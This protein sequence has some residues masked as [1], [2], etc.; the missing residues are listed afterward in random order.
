MCKKFILFVCM[1]F[2][3]SITAAVYADGEAYIE[4][5]GESVNVESV[6]FQS[7]SLTYIKKADK[8]GYKI[9][10]ESASDKLYIDI[11]NSFIYAKTGQPVEVEVGYYDEGSCSL[12]IGYAGFD[13]NIYKEKITEAVS[14]NNTCEWKTHT[15][16]ISD[17]AF[18]DSCPGKE[19]YDIFVKAAGE[20]EGDYV[21]VSS[22]R[23]TKKAAAIPVTFNIQGTVRG[24]IY[25]DGG[26]TF[27]AVFMN[28]AE[29]HTNVSVRYFVYDEN[30]SLAESGMQNSLALDA[31][32][33]EASV[34]RTNIKKYGVYTLKLETVSR[35]ESGERVMYSESLPFSVINKTTDG[36]VNLDFGISAH[37]D[38]YGNQTENV[39]IIKSAGFG[40]IR[41]ELS[42]FYV[43]HYSNP[44]GDLKI[45]ENKG[46]FQSYVVQNGMDNLMILGF[47]SAH[48]LESASIPPYTDEELEAFANY[49]AFMAEQYKDSV[50]YFEIWNEYNL[51][52]FNTP[53]YDGTVYAKMLKYAYEAIKGAN[54]NAK[55]VGMSLAGLTVGEKYGT[56]WDTF[57][58]QALSA[59]AGNYL[60]IL[61]VHFYQHDNEG[62]Y[63][64]EFFRTQK[65]KP[66]NEILA[67]YNVSLPI[68]LTETGWS[69]V[70][71]DK[72]A[73]PVSEKQQA[74]YGVKLYLFSKAEHLWNRM[75]WYDYQNDGADT[76]ENQHNFGL[77]DAASGVKAPG[78]AKSAFVAFAGMNKLMAGTRFKGRIEREGA[79]ILWFEKDN[80]E[81]VAALWSDGRDGN[82]INLSLG[83]DKIEILD[84]Y[85][86]VKETVRN[87]LGIYSVTFGDEPIYIRGDFVRFEEAEAVPMINI[88]IPDE[89]TYS[90]DVP[91]FK[92]VTDNT[93][94]D[95]KA[96]SVK[97][98]LK[99]YKNDEI[100]D[101]QEII[102]TAEANSIRYMP[103]SAFDAGVGEFRYE[104]SAAVGDNEVSAVKEY[105]VIKAE[106]DEFCNISYADN[107]LCVSG[108]AVRSRKCVSITVL[109]INTK[110]TIYIGQ[111]TAD[112]YGNYEFEPSGISAA[113]F[114]VTVNDGVLNSRDFHADDVCV[115]LLHN[116][117]SIKD[118]S[119]LKDGDVVE[120]YMTVNNTAADEKV[121]VIIAAY[122]GV[123]L[124]WAKSKMLRLSEGTGSVNVSMEQADKTDRLAC[125]VWTENMQPAAAKYVAVRME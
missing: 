106:D 41:D 22:V 42:W 58:E 74:M 6:V 107:K 82:K 27:S 46:R 20:N 21:A 34:I 87:S 19:G 57:L 63:T 64:E 3:L 83:T 62:V 100:A 23:V 35:L 1:I 40:I 12:A 69:N 73:N 66:L 24:N 113:E 95:S 79:E 8:Y 11:S 56:S 17:A 118:V 10:N 50:E 112:E 117:E 47:S 81:D 78:R 70:I 103:F 114:N 111:T 33:S 9:S 32:G 122:D 45:P 14:L 80:G 125:F 101:F 13:G 104:I 120:A 96:V 15:F 86:N 60:D 4:A 108:K 68:W 39:D 16:Y 88:E 97:L 38:K 119:L 49:C 110:D 5:K 124:L 31:S 93:A 121:N 29:Y 7:G 92:L 84:M 94:S 18:T 61:S 59:G 48:Y 123:K 109:D 85:S 55:V 53:N 67:K 30:N 43:E 52:N 28:Q 116:A 2:V 25:D 71:N 90:G 37:L 51:V 76:T 105:T 115:R 65:V 44:K 91:R 77:V 89:N 36:N 75:F 98:G 99:L 102:F 54:P 26:Q 72:V